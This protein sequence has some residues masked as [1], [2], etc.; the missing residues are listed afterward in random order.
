MLLTLPWHAKAAIIGFDTLVY[1]ANTRPSNETQNHDTSA[2]KQSEAS[3]RIVLEAQMYGTMIQI[4]ILYILAT[5]AVLAP[6]I[7]VSVKNREHT[8]TAI[9]HVLSLLNFFIYIVLTATE[10]LV[11]VE[12]VCYCLQFCICYTSFY[13]WTQASADRLLFTGNTYVKNFNAVFMYLFPA[14][15]SVALMNGMHLSPYVIP[16][17]FAGEIAG[18]CST[19]STISINTFISLFS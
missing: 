15:F 2:P 12:H 3:N 9:S 10:K 16:I 5:F 11:E 8:N 18:V 1:M 19:I 4:F 6:S 13:L 14:M 7:I 17:T